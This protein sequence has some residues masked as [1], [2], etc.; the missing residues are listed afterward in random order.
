MAQISLR[1]ESGRAL[2]SRPARRVRATGQVPAV[3]Y[4][5]GA[6]PRHIAVDHHDLSV[7]FHTPAGVNVLIN[8]EIDGEEGVPTLVR[9][10]DHH[11]FRNQ[12]R[13]VDFVRVSLTEKVKA[14]VN[15]HFVGTPAG[16]REGGILS[17][18]RNSVEIE[19]LPTEI[20]P[21]ID[22]DVS[23]LAINDDLYVRDIPAMEGVTILEDPDEMIVTVTTPAAEVV[24]PVPVEEGEGEEGEG[25][26]G[27][28]KPE[29]EE[30]ESE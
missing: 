23:G 2:G 8:L 6:A 16:V 10:I 7:A 26:E 28:P 21:T 29:G 30:E 12:I 18:I 4:G 25:E 17:P 20:P 27:A 19:A 1:A 3:I 22:V 14:E 11:P 13:H 5:K 24:E 15:L 9:A